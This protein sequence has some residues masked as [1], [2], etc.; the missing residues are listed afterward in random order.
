MADV[1][2]AP[3]RRIKTRE[4]DT[5]A[6]R[7]KLPA[8]KNPYWAGISGGRGGV[9]LGYRKGAGGGVWVVK[10]VIDGQRTEER[11]GLA[12]DEEN[13]SAGCLSFPAAVSAALD[14]SKQQIAI[15]EANAEALRD[16]AVPTV[17]S[18]VEAYAAQ[19][20]KAAGGRQTSVEALLAHIP[21]DS[22]FA[23]LRFAKL[24][25]NAIQEWLAQMQ[26]C[27]KR[28]G[29]RKSKSADVD[30]R[31]LAPGSRNR[32]L[33]DLRAAFNAAASRHRREIPA[34]LHAEIKAGTRTEPVDSEARKQLLTE[35]QVG[36]I[37]SAAFEVDE[38]FGYVVLIAAVTG[39]R[40]SQI[41]RLTVADVQVV[42][43]RIMMP[44]SR[45]GRN[46]KPHP[47]AAIPVHADVMARL[48]SLVIGRADGEPLLTRWVY[49]RMA[50]P[51]R[52][53]KEKRRTWGRAFEIGKPWAKTI[54]LAG[55]PA[56]TIMYALR[57]TSIVRGLI[58]GLPVRLVAALHD[59]SV[60]MIEKHYSAFITDMSDELARPYA[61]SFT[62][63][64]LAQAAE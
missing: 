19:R 42:K 4:I 46:R 15:V 45:K 55:V 16:A 48:G 26:R 53:V 14:W 8:R 59:T 34:H 44:T 33:G 50:K 30:L 20:K 7:A 47:P 23:K 41:V 61:V 62:S 27:P 3:G 43:S 58:A 63:P 64:P 5:V 2:E 13:A 51:A 17:R 9:S 6:K 35:A 52:W 54:N 12:A 31:P 29:K 56:D 38:D 28:K 40:Y 49:K 18:V 36:S 1:V 24:T 39:A 25:E 57:H 60:A 10:I 11:L 22:K 32:M 21:V 37:V